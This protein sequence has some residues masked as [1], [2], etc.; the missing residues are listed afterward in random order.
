MDGVTFANEFLNMRRVKPLFFLIQIIN[1][2]LTVLQYTISSFY[3][4]EAK[5]M[6]SFTKLF[7]ILIYKIGKAPICS[8]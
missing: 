7:F 5:F 8:S 4:L 3:S 1:T 2:T 6:K